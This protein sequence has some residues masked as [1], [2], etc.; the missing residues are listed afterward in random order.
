MLYTC[1][2]M[3]TVG[4]E[5]LKLCLNVKFTFVA[6]ATV[7]AVAM[8]VLAMVAVVT[9]WQWC[10][11]TLLRRTFVSCVRKTRRSVKR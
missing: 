10:V 3:V 1:T 7:L 4:V 6:I 11:R 8:V 2:R 9:V 5:G